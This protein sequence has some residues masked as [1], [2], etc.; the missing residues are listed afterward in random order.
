MTWYFVPKSLRE[1]QDA[2]KKWLNNLQLILDS[3]YLYSE[4]VIDG[5]V[6]ELKLSFHDGTLRISD[7]EFVDL[8]CV[9]IVEKKI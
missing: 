3:G 1:E 9:E 6:E 4:I 5:I 7:S 8:T 2:R